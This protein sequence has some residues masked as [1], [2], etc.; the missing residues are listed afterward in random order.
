MGTLC[1][2]AFVDIEAAKW[3]GGIAAGGVF[4]YLFGKAS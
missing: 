2:L 4:G 3:F 1:I